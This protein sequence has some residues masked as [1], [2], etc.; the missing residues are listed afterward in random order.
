[1]TIDEAT[2]LDT[3]DFQFWDKKGNFVIHEDWGKWM[4]CKRRG[5]DAYF[6]PDEMTGDELNALIQQCEKDGNDKALIA[7]LKDFPVPKEEI[8]A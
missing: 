3:L 1:M 6:I 5:G 8:G 7:R 2:D 4:Y